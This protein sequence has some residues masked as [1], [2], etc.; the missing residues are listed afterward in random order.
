MLAELGAAFWGVYT[1]V[2][3]QEK[4]LSRKAVDMAWRERILAGLPFLGV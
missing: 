3:T 2:V 4:K 1:G